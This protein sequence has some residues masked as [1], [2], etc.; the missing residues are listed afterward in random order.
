MNNISRNFE[1]KFQIHLSSTKAMFQYMTIADPLFIGAGSDLYKKCS[2]HRHQ[3]LSPPP[4][5]SIYPYPD[6]SINTIMKN[7][8]ASLKLILEKGEKSEKRPNHLAHNISSK[9]ITKQGPR[10]TK[11]IHS[12]S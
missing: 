12:T 8:L 2:S 1:S 9:T 4:H 11:L 7:N 10:K 5:H 3:L 6:L